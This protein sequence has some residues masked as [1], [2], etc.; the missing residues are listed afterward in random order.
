MDIEE[1]KNRIEQAH[2]I[3]GIPTYWEELQNMTEERDQ[4]R[5]LASGILGS[6]GHQEYCKSIIEEYILIDDN[7]CN[8][9]LDEWGDKYDVYSESKNYRSAHL[10]MEDGPERTKYNRFRRRTVIKLD[11]EQCQ[12]LSKDN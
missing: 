9:G 3:T 10:W 8:C 12:E 4:W 6:A 1:Y 5:E 2:T 7:D 11:D